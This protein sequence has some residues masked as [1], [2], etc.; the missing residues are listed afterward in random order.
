MIVTIGGHVC[1]AYMASVDSPVPDIN[2]LGRD[3]M[4]LCGVCK[5]VDNG[6]RQ[7]ILDFCGKFKLVEPSEA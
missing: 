1:P 7:V 3:F 6:K 5:L 4:A 2:F